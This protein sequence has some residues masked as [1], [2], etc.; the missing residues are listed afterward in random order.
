MSNLNSVLDESFFHRLRYLVIPYLDYATCHGIDHTDRVYNISKVIAN[1]EKT[2]IDIVRAS[3]LLHDIARTK[4]KYGNSIT[5]KDTICHAEEGARMAEEL[6]KKEIQFPAFKIPQ[7]SYAISVHRFSKHLK[8]ETIEAKILQDADR[9][10]AL[11]AV[12]IAR[13]IKSSVYYGYPIHDS[14]IPAK[15]VYDGEITTAI[16]HFYEK[17][18]KM[19]PESFNTS[20]GRR[21]A[22]GRY[23]FVEEFVTRYVEEIEGD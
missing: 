19:K 17:I 2:D 20:E 14:S 18:L 15:P 4:E 6:L 22:E 1:T 21:I 12:I 8:A 10:D 7:V 11:G 23:E 13:T 3:A 5:R 9:L 16:N